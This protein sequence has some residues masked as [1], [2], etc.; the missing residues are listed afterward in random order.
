M[1]F[2]AD[3]THVTSALDNTP[4]SDARGTTGASEMSAPS[5]GSASEGSSDARAAAAAIEQCLKD[6]YC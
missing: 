3:A 2:S 1:S 5:K 4:T 6:L